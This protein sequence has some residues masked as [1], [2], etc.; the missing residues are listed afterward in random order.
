MGNTPLTGR[1]CSVRTGTTGTVINSLG[2]WEITVAT[3]TQEVGEFGSYWKKSLPMMMGWVGR[4]EGFMDAST[5]ATD[6]LVV[7]ANGMLDATKNQDIKFYLQ[8]SSGLMIMPMCATSATVSSTDAGCYITNVAVTADYND[9][10]RVSYDVVGYGA[11][12]FFNG[13]SSGVIV[14]ESTA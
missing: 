8:T 3:D 2:H 6:Q 11:L 9:L 10:A 7:L 13:T 14:V 5:L 12:G 4:V 1:Y